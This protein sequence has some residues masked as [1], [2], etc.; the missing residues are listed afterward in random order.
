MQFATQLVSV[1]ALVVVF[2]FWTTRAPLNNFWPLMC[3][4]L[5]AWVVM[6]FQVHHARIVGTLGVRALAAQCA[7]GWDDEEDGPTVAE[8]TAA[9][10]GLRDM[11]AAAEAA[12][13]Q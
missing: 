2:L 10:A 13:A 4:W 3:F 12:A 8:L 9:L 11:Y 7:A 1:S 6:A 5:C